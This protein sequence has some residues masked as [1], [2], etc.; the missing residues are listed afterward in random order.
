MQRKGSMSESISQLPRWT[1]WCL[2][3]AGV[4]NIAW[5]AVTI[6]FPHLLFDAVGIPR[7]KYHEI[8]QCVG[9]IVEVYRVG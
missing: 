4:Y 7:M 8:W 6:L 9:M 5:G 1:Y 3:I 2:W